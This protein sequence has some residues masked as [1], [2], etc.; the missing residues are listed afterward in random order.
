MTFVFY[1]FLFLVIGTLL[2]EMA[3]RV[4]FWMKS[5]FFVHEVTRRDFLNKEYH[6]FLD[7][8][9]D[10]S[11]PMFAYLPI[12]VRYH[13][14]DHMPE[15]IKIND[16]GFR[17]DQFKMPAE[18]ELSIIVMGGSAAWGFG[19]LN[20]KH[21]IPKKL[22]A[23]I[24]ANIE[25]FPGKSKCKV[26]NLAQVDGRITQDIINLIMHGPSLKPDLVVC[27]N[28]WNEIA[29][30][31]VLNP[32]LLKKWRCYF[33]NELAGWEDY[34]YGDNDTR[35]LKRVTLN[36]FERRTRIGQLFFAKQEGCLPSSVDDRINASS[37]IFAEN[38]ARMNIVADGFG[39]ECYNFF[40]PNAYRKKIKSEDEAKVIELYDDFRP[41]EGGKK[42]G[43]EFATKNL[44]EKV[45]SNE[46]LAQAKLFDLSDIFY[47]DK[48]GCFYSLVHCTEYGYDRL[49][50]AIF[51]TIIETSKLSIGRQANV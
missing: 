3:L 36:W 26:W 29:S 9:E 10:D 2:V 42:N 19:C 49:A 13:N 47:E 44:Y 25:K 16:F 4:F 45:V 41:V 5:A 24:N 17:D 21:T 30:S 12:G 34:R 48:E 28:G 37:D 18:D 35:L 8:I 40:Q 31:F 22:E 7:W 23:L 33:L 51:N 20:E 1:I 38:I 50:H 32:K 14:H 11:N 46:S 39:I 27:F 15:G 6:P 43:L